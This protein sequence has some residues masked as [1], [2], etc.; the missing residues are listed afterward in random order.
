MIW[1]VFCG[2]LFFFWT[3]PIMSHDQRL[4]APMIETW[5]RPTVHGIQKKAPEYWGGVLCEK[6]PT[7]WGI[8]MNAL[9]S[10]HDAKTWVGWW[11]AQGIYIMVLQIKAQTSGPS[12]PSGP[13]GHYSRA[14]FEKEC[15]YAIL[16]ILDWNWNVL[17][18]IY[19]QL[20]SSTV[21][22]DIFSSW[23]LWI[24][25]RAEFLS[26]LLHDQGQAEI[27]HQKWD[28]TRTASILCGWSMGYT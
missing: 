15:Q 20:S 6:T 16:F 10:S 28:V 19:V 12:G 24:S 14:G 11:T 2:R 3:F 7:S 27:K 18:I 22:P 13:S 8:C 4:A 21:H 25:N 9:T 1:Y 23:R 26:K 17:Y 5:S